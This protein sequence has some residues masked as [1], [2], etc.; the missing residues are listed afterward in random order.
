MGTSAQH[1][2]QHK[3]P[4]SRK[5][6]FNF[7]QT[8][9]DTERGDPAFAWVWEQYRSPAAQHPAS[10]LSQ[11]GKTGNPERCPRELHCTQHG[12]E[13]GHGSGMACL[14]LAPGAVFKNPPRLVRRD[15]LQDL[16]ATCVHK[17]KKGMV[18]SLQFVGLWPQKTETSTEQIK[19][20]V[21]MT[22]GGL[23][24]LKDPAQWHYSKV[25]YTMWDCHQ[26]TQFT[27]RRRMRRWMEQKLQELPNAINKNQPE[28]KEPP[29]A[30][31]A[32]TDAAST[33]GHHEIGPQDLLHA[34]ATTE[35]CAAGQCVSD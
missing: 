2:Q 12:P 17:G 32:A 23:W 28:Q 25:S 31:L 21:W 7:I 27:S 8:T 29:N 26:P 14:P 9:Q 1:T 34:C 33:N 6:A 16:R 20:G 5:T 11:A 19:L 4:T 24:I 13:D 22:V 15:G 10:Q 3:L 18:D 30:T 35:P